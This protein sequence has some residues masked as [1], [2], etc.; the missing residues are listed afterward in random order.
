MKCFVQNTTFLIISYSKIRQWRGPG[1]LIVNFE[2]ISNIA[3]V[4]PLM[5][6][7]K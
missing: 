4:F 1:A 5:S 2:Q 7:N 3:L 6:F